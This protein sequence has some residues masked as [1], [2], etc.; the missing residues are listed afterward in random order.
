[1]FCEN[2]GACAEL[3]Q[4]ESTVTE[5]KVNPLSES[6]KR[7]GRSAGSAKRE[8]DGPSGRFI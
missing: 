4:E 2:D 5:R 7:Y 6:R 3:A 8:Y 1:M